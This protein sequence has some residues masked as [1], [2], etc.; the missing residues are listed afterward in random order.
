MD[1]SLIEELRLEVSEATYR[2]EELERHV[3]HLQREL[4]LERDEN[5]ALRKDLDEQ[6]A[7]VA[8]HLLLED[9]V[10]LLCDCI[11]QI[12][13]F[14]MLEDPLEMHMLYR[15]L[16]VVY[17]LLRDPVPITENAARLRALKG[18]G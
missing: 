10:T 8:D 2:I 16:E 6:E 1:D 14:E 18:T 11:S 7:T 12:A 5:H 9:A 13:G 15:H 17:D 4:D 3:A